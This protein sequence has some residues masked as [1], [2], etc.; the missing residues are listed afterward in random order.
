MAIQHGASVGLCF[1]FAATIIACPAL[2]AE[3][4][5]PVAFR[6]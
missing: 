2:P 6:L 4:R 5:A 1:A 3:M